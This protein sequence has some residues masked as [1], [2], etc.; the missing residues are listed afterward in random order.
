[1]ASWKSKAHKHVGGLPFDRSPASK[2]FADH[3]FTPVRTLP[4]RKPVAPLDVH[5]HG[6]LS[7]G[8]DTSRINRG[9]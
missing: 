4:G 6:S 2:R 7:H 1:M 3:V 8:P 5:P 9:G